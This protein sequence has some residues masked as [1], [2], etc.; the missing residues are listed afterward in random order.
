MQKLNCKN[1]TLWLFVAH[2]QEF[3]RYCMKMRTDTDMKRRNCLHRVK[4]SFA[5]Y[6]AMQLLIPHIKL[7]SYNPYA[8]ISTLKRCLERAAAGSCQFMLFRKYKKET[9]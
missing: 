1:G 6:S 8:S 4:L 2:C 5:M 7:L 3:V 9:E